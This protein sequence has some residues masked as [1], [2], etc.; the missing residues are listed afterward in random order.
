MAAGIS[1]RRG[2]GA[3]LQGSGA[4]VHG[5]E[6]WVVQEGGWRGCRGMQG[7]GAQGPR[8]RTPRMAAVRWRRCVGRRHEGRA[9]GAREEVVV[10]GTRRDGGAGI[11]GGD[12]GGT[13]PAAEARGARR[14]SGAPSF[15]SRDTRGRGA[16]Q[17]WVHGDAGG[18]H[19]AG[20]Q[21]L[22]RS[23]FIG[24]ATLGRRGAHAK[25]PGGHVEF[26]PRTT[27]LGSGLVW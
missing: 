20:T 4:C 23:H 21:G 22:K 27:G 2:G 16:G 15:T 8:A 18:G 14:G 13:G 6:A 25:A 3:L 9:E 24:G 7:Q 19:T 5:E 17:A 12:A 11:A 26:L 10:Q 1:P